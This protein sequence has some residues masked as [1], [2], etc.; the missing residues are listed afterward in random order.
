MQLSGWPWSHVGAN[1]WLQDIREVQAW[2]DSL[3]GTVI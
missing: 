3:N 2:P 1:M